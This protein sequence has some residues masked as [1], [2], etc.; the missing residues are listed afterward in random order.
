M[1]EHASSCVQ[2]FLNDLFLSDCYRM[3]M[4]YRRYLWEAGGGKP[5]GMHAGERREAQYIEFV[6]AEKMNEGLGEGCN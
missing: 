5:N 3:E 1:C 6:S 2:D 4:F